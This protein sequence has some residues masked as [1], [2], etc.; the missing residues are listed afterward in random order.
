MIAWKITEKG[1]TFIFQKGNFEFEDEI[2]VKQA[3]E[4]AKAVHQAIPYWKRHSTNVTEP[5]KEE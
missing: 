3:K 4:I 1:I 2:T 5:I